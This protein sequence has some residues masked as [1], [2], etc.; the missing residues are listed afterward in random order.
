[1]TK[2]FHEI[3]NNE[4]IKDEIIVL[5]YKFLCDYY[6]SR[7]I[8]LKDIPWIELNNLRKIL[9]KDNFE[10]VC[11]LNNNKLLLDCFNELLKKYNIEKK[12]NIS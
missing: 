1:M 10:D 3:N 11:I 2:L 5:V 4:S 7:K 8:Y 6:E 12:D 9:N